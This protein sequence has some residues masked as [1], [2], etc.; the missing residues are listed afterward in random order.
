VVRLNSNIFVFV[1]LLV[2]LSGSAYSQRTALHDN[3]VI[4]GNQTGMKQ[5]SQSKMTSYFE[6]RIK[7]WPSLEKV[8]VV[9]PSSKHK[10]VE[11]YS[12]VIYD[13]SFYSVKKFWFSLVFQGRFDAPFFLDTDEEII[14]FVRTNRGS[15]A[16][17]HNNESIPDQLIIK[18]N[19]HE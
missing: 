2:I 18:I 10:S 9:L 8:K 11:E 16:L 3:Y 6:G 19:G 7:K 12:N 14:E 15:F 17:V 13:K 4:I 5:V 1:L